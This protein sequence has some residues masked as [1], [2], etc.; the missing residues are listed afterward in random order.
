MIKIAIIDDEE[1]MSSILSNYVNKYAKEK[2]IDINM[3]IFQ[4]STD[5]LT[6][7]SGYD[8]IFMDIKIKND[9]DGM[10]TARRLRLKDSSTTLIFVTSY[11]QFAVKRYEVMA[12]DFIIKPIIYEDFS[13]RFT[14]ALK[15]INKDINNN[16]VE[17]KFGNNIKSFL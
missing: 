8:I 3:D 15:H 6:N 9:I 11:E 17:I 16:T 7:Y 14:R 2:N 12:F 13:L 10:E 4:S 5:F 1:E